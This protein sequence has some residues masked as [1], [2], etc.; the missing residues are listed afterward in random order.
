MQ[1]FKHKYWTGKT[2][3]LLLKMKYFRGSIQLLLSGHESVTQISKQ[4]S[5]WLL[6]HFTENHKGQQNK[7]KKQ[8]IHE[9]G[10]LCVIPYY[11]FPPDF[12]SSPFELEMFQF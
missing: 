7:I 9:S 4:T 3:D 8:H 1:V 11:S 5:E 10:D 12:L 6:S 2:D